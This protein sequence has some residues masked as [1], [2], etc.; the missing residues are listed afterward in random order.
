MCLEV[1]FCPLLFHW[2]T[3]RT[4]FSSR[5]E[6]ESVRGS[7]GV[8]LVAGLTRRRRHEGT[9]NVN[10]NRRFVVNNCIDSVLYRRYRTVAYHIG[11]TFLLD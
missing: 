6:F 10:R 11:F 2:R 4:C 8:H 3:F 1:V 9:S 5:I 7:E